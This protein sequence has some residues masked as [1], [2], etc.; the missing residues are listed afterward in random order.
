[1]PIV[2]D[3]NKKQ[4]TRQIAKNA[5]AV[6]QNKQKF[7]VSKGKNKNGIYEYDY[8]IKY[9]SI[10]L[11]RVDKHIKSANN[12]ITPLGPANMR[13][14]EMTEYNRFKLPNPD[15]TLSRGFMHVFFTKP[16][17]N[18]IGSDGKANSQLK[19][20]PTIKYY[21]QHNKD[22]IYSLVKKNKQKHQDDFNYFLSN[23]AES[24]TPK[25]K[26]ITT[27]KYGTSYTGYAIQFGRHAHDSLG[28]DQFDIQ[29]TDDYDLSVLHMHEIWTKY[30]ENVYRGRWSPRIEYIYKKILDYACS[31]YV[32]LTAED[33]ETILYWEKYYG[34]FPINVPYSALSWNAGAPL[35]HPQYTISYAYSWREPMNP[36]ALAEFNTNRFRKGSTPSNKKTGLSFL[37]PF[38]TTGK[39]DDYKEKHGIYRTGNTWSSG[40]YIETITNGATVTHAGVSRSY[41]T[42]VGGNE[43]I[44]YKLRFSPLTT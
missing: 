20:D 9:S 11:D 3:V 32:I 15:Y 37:L 36:T 40:P 38:A 42:R 7:P 22:L 21:Y 26:S 1:M 31:C 14:K 44:E 13:K 4:R 29:Y 25:D 30:I 5:P 35:T 6:V 43:S 18:L 12:L 39:I 19:D 2:P 16:D 10:N 23:R 24:F 27:D 28:A 17:L 34:V 8:N 41:L 33:G